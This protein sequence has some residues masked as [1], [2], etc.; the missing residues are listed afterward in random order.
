MGEVEVHF[1][2]PGI[3]E[4]IDRYTKEAGVRSL[5]RQISAV[6]RKLAVEY[7]RDKKKKKSFKADV[8]TVQRLLGPAKYRFNMGDAHDQ[9]GMVNGL[10]V[11]TFGGDLL[12]AEASVIAGKGKVTLTGKLGEVMQESAQAAISYVR[13][14]SLAFGLEPDFYESLDFHVHFPEGAVPKDGPSAG[15]TI[16]VALVSALLRMPVRKDVAM[17]G[18]I[19]LR[20]KVLPIGGLKEKVLAAFRGGMKT[21]ICPKENEKDLADIPKNVLRTLTINLATNLDEVLRWAI[22]PPDENHANSAFRDFMNGVDTAPVDWRDVH[23]YLE[24]R[25]R[26]ERDE[27]REHGPH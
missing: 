8:R 22:V 24:E 23:A 1:T 20:G 15:V 25:K 10:A 2:D 18:E 14:R 9:V 19:N 17:T 5:E 26:K 12:P 21:V 16:V 13:S 7:I 3:R 6:A 27:R 4:I 11:T